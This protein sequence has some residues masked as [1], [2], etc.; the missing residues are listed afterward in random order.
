MSPRRAAFSR[1]R[2][3]LWFCPPTVTLTSSVAVAFHCE[4]R[5]RVFE[6]DILRLGTAMV[7][8][9]PYFS[10]FWF[11]RPRRASMLGAASDNQHTIAGSG[12]E[13]QICPV[14]SA[15]TRRVTATTYRI[16]SP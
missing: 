7:A 15:P 5:L 10:G 13:L 12:H 9:S 8:P 1:R 14:P 11:I 2:G 3:T 6:R 4:R 16:F